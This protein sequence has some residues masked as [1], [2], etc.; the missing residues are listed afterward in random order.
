MTIPD[1]LALRRFVNDER[2][3]ATERRAIRG[4]VVDLERR[5][6]HKLD[7]AAA[8]LYYLARFAVGGGLPQTRESIPASARAYH[9]FVAVQAKARREEIVTPKSR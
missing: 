4:V 7:T 2:L 9:H 3:T 1:V 6:L 8:V 5:G